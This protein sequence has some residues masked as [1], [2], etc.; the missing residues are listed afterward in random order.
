MTYTTLKHK[1]DC[2]IFFS[3]FLYIYVIVLIN[4]YFSQ[5]IVSV[6]YTHE[7]LVEI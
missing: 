4:N 5:L 7:N 3:N 2:N 1:D 6:L